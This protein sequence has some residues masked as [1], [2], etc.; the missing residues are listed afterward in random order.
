ML[1]KTNTQSVSLNRPIILSSLQTLC[2]FTSD[3]V[4]F[5]SLI[6]QSLSP[7]IFAFTVTTILATS[8]IANPILSLVPTFKKQKEPDFKLESS[9]SE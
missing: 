7:Q 6:L 3:A 1:G 4:F 8:T 2:W 5:L 9:L